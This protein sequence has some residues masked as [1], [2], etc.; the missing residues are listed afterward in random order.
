MFERLDTFIEEESDEM[1]FTGGWGD[2][3]IQELEQ[4]IGNS[5]REELKVFI[6]K[7][8]LLMGYGLEICACGRTGASQM[9]DDTISLRKCGLDNKYIVIMNNGEIVYCLDNET[10]KIVNW[11]LDNCEAYPEA[12]DM[13]SFIM[14]YLNEAKEDW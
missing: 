8:G 1:F 10:G 2:D 9:V 6:Q 14:T 7:Y 11:G 4:R 13:E 12:D 5:F 3:K